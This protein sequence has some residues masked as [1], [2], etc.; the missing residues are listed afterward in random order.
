MARGPSEEGT[1]TTDDAPGANLTQLHDELV[2]KEQEVRLMVGEVEPKP[3]SSRAGA[4]GVW[5]NARS[6]SRA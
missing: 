6:W 2:A 4:D 3:T 1:R 5:S